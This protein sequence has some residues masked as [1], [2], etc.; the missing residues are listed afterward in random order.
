MAAR[1]PCPGT[2]PVALPCAFEFGHKGD[3]GPFVGE[4]QTAWFRLTVKLYADGRS[5]HEVKDIV[6]KALADAG[7]TGEVR[8]I[9]EA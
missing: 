9:G 2:Y 7:E 6:E 1:K 5:P 4:P 3:C 8:A